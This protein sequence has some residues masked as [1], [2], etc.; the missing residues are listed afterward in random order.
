V[1]KGERQSLK[2]RHGGHFLDAIDEKRGSGVAQDE[3]KRRRRSWKAEVQR[4]VH[5][6]KREFAAL[7][8]LADF[9]KRRLG[10]VLG[11][12][13]ESVDAADLLHG[14]GGKSKQL[15]AYAK[16]YDLLS[17]RGVRFWGRGQA[18]H[19]TPTGVALQMPI[20]RFSMAA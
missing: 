9:A 8:G 15:A 5:D 16:E 1:A 7:H 18:H 19:L 2:A 6:V 14:S 3:D 11:R 20:T 4:T 17:A 13:G 12:S 10:N